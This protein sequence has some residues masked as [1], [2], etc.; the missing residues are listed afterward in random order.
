MVVELALGEADGHDA[1][2]GPVG[3]RKLRRRRAVLV[4]RDVELGAHLPERLQVGHVQRVGLPERAVHRKQ[5]AAGQSQRLDCA[6][7]GHGIVDVPEHHLRDPGP[8]V[9]GGGAEI[10]QPAVVRLQAGPTAL[11]IS[12]VL[13]VA[14]GQH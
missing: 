3:R 1:R 7:L 5:D 4:D 14:A 2:P 13:G 6:D 10:R 9:R 12:A 11:V 8:P